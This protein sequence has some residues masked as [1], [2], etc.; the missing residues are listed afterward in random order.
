MVLVRQ[1]EYKQD[2]SKT[3]QAKGKTRDRN[4]T[5]RGDV[6]I[7]AGF[8]NQSLPVVLFVCVCVCVCVCVLSAL[9]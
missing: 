7:S 9:L 8:P 3:H 1:R 6:R 4:N 2:H 5:E